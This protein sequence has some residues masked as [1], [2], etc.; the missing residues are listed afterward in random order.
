MLSKMLT[1]TLEEVSKDTT[2]DDNANVIQEVQDDVKEA[3]SP[4]ETWLV[5]EYLNDHLAGDAF[6]SY[7]N[8]VQ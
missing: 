6:L 3:S 1:K 8:K 2:K 7:W 5:R 4:L